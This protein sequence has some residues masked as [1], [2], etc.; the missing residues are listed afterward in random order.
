MKAAIFAVGSL[1]SLFVSMFTALML[2]ALKA[3]ETLEGVAPSG[4][5][6]AILKSSSA[7][8]LIFA[9][10]LLILSYRS[11]SAIKRGSE[12]KTS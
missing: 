10:T 6:V 7:L 2:L 5:K 4:G 3:T 12:T 1:I 11:V 9:V 8:F